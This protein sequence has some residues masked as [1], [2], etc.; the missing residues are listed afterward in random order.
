M[1]FHRI[2]ALVRSNKKWPT[3]KPR[4]TIMTTKNLKGTAPIKNS[5]TLYPFD[6]QQIRQSAETITEDLMEDLPGL[7]VGEAIITG[8]ILRAPAMVKIDKFAEKLGGDDI[9]I[10]KA[11]STVA[12][13]LT[14]RKTGTQDYNKDSDPF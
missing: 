10:V 5:G 3:S 4:S 13:N 11:W 12:D 7:N 8:S 6:Q 2:S 1:T 9:D 14:S